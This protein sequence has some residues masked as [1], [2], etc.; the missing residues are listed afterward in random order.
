MSYEGSYYVCKD[1]A[2]SSITQVYWTKIAVN[3]N[4]KALTAVKL[5]D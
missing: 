3:V 4:M 2:K 5:I 1:S